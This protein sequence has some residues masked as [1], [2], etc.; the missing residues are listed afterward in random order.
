MNRFLA[1]LAATSAIVVSGAAAMPTPVLAA[2]TTIS[3]SL[4]SA[5]AGYKVFMIGR[6]GSTQVATADATGA[7]RLTT[8]RTRARSASLQMVNTA[9]QY[10]GPIVI[11]KE[12]VG[13][14]WCAHTKLAG[15]SV[16]LGTLTRVAEGF[17]IPTKAPKASTYSRAAILA[18][19]STGKPLAAGSGGIVKVSSAQSRACAKA[20]V[21]VKSV[22]ALEANGTLIGA[23]L[24]S[25]GLPNALDADDDGDKVIDAVD[26]TTGNT[27]ALNPTAALRT[28]NATFNANITTSLTPADVAAVLGTSGNY[29]INFFIGQYLLSATNGINDVNWTSVDCGALVYCGRSTPTAYNLN[30]HLANNTTGVPWNTYFGGFARETSSSLATNGINTNLGIDPNSKG[31]ALYLMNRNNATDPSYV[32]WLASMFP[33]Q[34]SNTLNTVKPGDVYTVRY[35]TAAG[36]QQIVMML[37]PHAITVPGLT[38]VNG[39]PYVSGAISPDA[40]G[41]IALSFFRPQRLT[42]TGEAGTFK[43]MGGLN[44]GIIWAPPGRGDTGCATSTYSGYENDFTATTGTDAAV[45]LWP[46]TDKVSTESDSGANAA[47]LSF[48]LDFRNCIGAA[49]YDAALVGTTWTVE[50]LSAGQ[51]LTGGSNRASVQLVVKK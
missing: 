2:S 7:F 21:G 13:R 40:N 5:G 18:K 22:S 28:T 37:N 17:A 51:L 25:D 45:Q 39:A 1:T 12:K 20:R 47:K 44:Y 27:A 42:T 38:T 15:V 48:T 4:G 34:G 23:D 46:L 35:N 11:A 29:S 14:N 31:N 9:N 10:A 33:N 49:T 32:Y 41:K 3:G 24:D 26:P 16:K 30:T 50:L 19:S 8:T 43:D 36:D 6:N